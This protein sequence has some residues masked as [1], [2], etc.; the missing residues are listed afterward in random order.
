MR[1]SQAFVPTLK[2]VPSEAEIASHQLMLR[3][4]LIRKLASGLYTYLPLGWRVIKKVEQII[5]EEMDR[6]GAL[7][8][9]MPQLHPIELWEQSGRAKIMG[10]EMMRLNDR[11]ERTFVLGPTHEEIITSL[12]ANEVRSYKQLPKNFY[13]IAT[14]FR[15]EIR[16]RFGVMRAREFIMK[17]A[18]SFDIDDAAAEKSYRGMYDAYSRMFKRC[19][20]TTVAVE[21]DTGAIGGSFSHEFMVPS[22]IGEEQMVSCSACGYSANLEQAECAVIQGA[23]ETDVKSAPVEVLTPNQKTIENV[24]KF[25]N[26][27]P[28]D[29]IKTLIYVAD[30]KPVAALI[31]GDHAINDVK[32][33]KAL[34]CEDLALATPEVI[35]QVTNAPLGFSGPIGLKDIRMIADS[36]VMVMKRA[37]VGGNQKDTHLTDVVPGRDFAPGTVTDIR[38]AMDKDPCPR[39]SKPEELSWGIEV[40]HCFKLGTKY[41]KAFDATYLDEKGNSQVMVMGCYGIGVTRTAAAVIESNHDKDGIIFP[42]S[43]APYHV[44][45]L[46]LNPSIP[47][48]LEYTEQLY[49]DLPLA[50][51]EVLYD[52]RDERPGVKF[53]DADL[54]GIPIRVTVGDR[55]FK[56]GMIEITLRK[57]K[58][59]QLVK[60]EELMA[61]LEQLK[62]QLTQDV[63]VEG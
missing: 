21:A 32:L 26:I 49:R 46:N 47:E 9:V 10:K 41:S 39:C 36:S 5:R 40:G 31:R 34:Q 20:L 38:V 12:V 51:Y 29:L 6:A 18:Y 56:Q 57:T 4:G 17:D 7:E 3:A 62:K 53:K 27:Q 35:L 43:V 59:S 60:Q 2:E 1:W 16:P 22:A 23:G 15:D 55:N 42:Y 37:V 61:V 58:E 25:L 50:G 8:L 48:M 30:G 24:A 11:S 19:G 28:S 13:Q 14:K 33:K 44:S 54:M 63:A 52:D 45:L